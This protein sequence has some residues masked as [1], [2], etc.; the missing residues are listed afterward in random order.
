MC[1]CVHFSIKL[2]IRQNS[3]T[4]GNKPLPLAAYNTTLYF[5]MF[6]RV[7]FRINLLL[8][9]LPYQDYKIQVTRTIY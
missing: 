3:L 2:D 5:N 1:V 7:A 8:D 6:R 9:W 4:H